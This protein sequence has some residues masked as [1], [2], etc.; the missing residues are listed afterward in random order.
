MCACGPVM[1]QIF[2]TFLPCIECLQE[3]RPKERIVWNLCLLLLPA[4]TTNIMQLVRFLHAARLTCLSNLHTDTNRPRNSHTQ[5]HQHG[6]IFYYS[7][8]QHCS[9]DHWITAK[10]HWENVDC[11]KLWLSTSIWHSLLHLSFRCYCSVFSLFHTQTDPHLPSPPYSFHFIALL[12]PSQCTSIA[13]PS[14]A[15][16]YLSLWFTLTLTP[17]FS[18]LLEEIS[19]G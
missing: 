19:R 1:P 16:R 7:F 15:C 12:S 4:S 3:K 13:T 14:S 9:H 17:I 6:W 2:T 10:Q 11:L 18:R 5:T 8:F